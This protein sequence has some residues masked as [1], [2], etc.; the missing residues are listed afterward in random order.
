MNASAGPLV[1]VAID[2]REAGLVKFRV[3][4]AADNFYRSDLRLGRQLAAGEAVNAD[5]GVV[6]GYLPQGPLHLLRVVGQ[7]VDLFA[8]QKIR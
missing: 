1:H 5:H 7:R 2:E 6:A 8:R 4:R 3:E